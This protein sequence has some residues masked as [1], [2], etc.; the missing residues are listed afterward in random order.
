[1]ARSIPARLT[2]SE[3]RRFG[4]TV[5]LAFLAL[6]SVAWWR[7]R[8][9]VSLILGVPGLLLVAAGLTM[10]TYLGPAERGWMRLAHAISRVTT[11][12]AMAAIYFLVLTVVGV[13][14][15]TF[16]GNELIQPEHEGSLWQP[17]PPGKRRSMSMERQ[18]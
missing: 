3:G 8:P 18:F 13:A 12:I 14:R 17:R 9:I 10:P 5:G 1:M 6:S 16:G 11:P 4:T 2:A 15:R 7:G